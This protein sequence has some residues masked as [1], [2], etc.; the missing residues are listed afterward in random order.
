MEKRG[1]L[2]VL[3]TALVS[4]AA[5]FLNKFGV[6]GINPYVFTFAKNVLVVLFLLSLLILFNDFK[7]FKSLKKT[8]WLKLVAIGFFGGSIPFLLFFKGLSMAPSTT[9]ALMH[10]SMF[11][12]VSILA[13]YF[14]KEKVDKKFIIAALLLFAGNFALL[15][16]TSFGLGIPDLYILIAVLLWTTETII[17]KHTLKEVPSR[18]V[19]FGRM[20]FGVLFILVFLAATGNITHLASLTISELGWIL[21]TAVFLLF[22]VT[23]WYAGLKRIPASS[24]ASVLVLGSAV[25]TALSIISAGSFNFI[26]VTGIILITG[27]VA[28][29]AGIFDIATKIKLILPSKN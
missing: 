21:F 12:F 11:I 29:L 8:Q 5:I 13:V 25:T 22:Y 27:G 10:K 19:A 4:G 9:A 3:S 14:L 18:V 23:T 2:L 17:S 16:I 6:S 26:D 28:A 15:N 24:A 1:Y 7:A 20:F